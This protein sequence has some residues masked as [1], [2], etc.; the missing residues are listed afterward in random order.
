LVR[1][2]LAHIKGK[3]LAEKI[4][5][6]IEDVDSDWFLRASTLEAVEIE[7]GAE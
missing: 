6:P 1:V 2:Y 4:L 5:P 3:P 7:P